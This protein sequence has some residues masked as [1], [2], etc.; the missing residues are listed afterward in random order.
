MYPAEAEGHADLFAYQGG[1]RDDEAQLRARPVAENDNGGADL[2]G[3]GQLFSAPQATEEADSF[4]L[5]CDAGTFSVDGQTASLPVSRTVVSDAGTFT[6][7]GQTAGLLWQPVVSAL[8][9]SFTLSGQTASLLWARTEACAAGGFALTGQTAGLLVNYPL[10]AA[11]ALYSVDGQNAGVVFGALLDASLIGSVGLF[12]A[13][14]QTASLPANRLVTADA[15]SYAFADQAATMPVVMPA[16]AGA[17]SLDGQ[18]AA[19]PALVSIACD[20]GDLVISGQPA[21]LAWAQYLAADAGAFV[22]DGRDLS[23]L[24]YRLLVADVGSIAVGGQTIGP[25][26]LVMPAL[27]GPISLDGQ[28]AQLYET[29]GGAAIDVPAML[30]I[31]LAARTDVRHA[32]ITSMRI[33]PSDAAITIIRARHQRG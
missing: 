22:F 3:Y 23:L 2:F 8:D 32:L 5:Q 27:Y 29:L 20:A 10:A 33:R 24:L 19:L 12:D 15:G 4:T 31:G 28:D 9:G 6:L 30:R 16:S 21:T 14:G 11:H 17:Y 1:V 18:A 26:S 7:S 13:T 25:W